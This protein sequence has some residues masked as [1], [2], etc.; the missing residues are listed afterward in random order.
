MEIA[1]APG[2]RFRVGRRFSVADREGT[3]KLVTPMLDGRFSK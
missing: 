1:A 3:T 2:P